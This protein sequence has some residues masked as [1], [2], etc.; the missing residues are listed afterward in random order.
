MY[1]GLPPYSPICPYRPL[2]NPYIPE[3]WPTAHIVKRPSLPNF[4]LTI[5]DAARQVVTHPILGTQ[6]LYQGTWG[7]IRVCRGIQGHTGFRIQG[8]SF[9][10]FCGMMEAPCP[11]TST[12]RSFFAP[13]LRDNSLHGALSQVSC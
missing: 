1:P 11:K 3:L 7:H 6:G 9:R 2:C 8:L 4:A 13:P 5:E 10:Y 12:E